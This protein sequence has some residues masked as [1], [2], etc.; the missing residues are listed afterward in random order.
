MKLV[1]VRH[2]SPSVLMNNDIGTR[3]FNGF[4]YIKQ[5]KINLKSTIIY[6]LQ[7]PGEAIHKLLRKWQTDHA[8][9]GS[10]TEGNTNTWNRLIEQSDPV[11]HRNLDKKSRH[12]KKEKSLTI[13]PEVIALC[14]E[15]ENIDPTAEIDLVE[16]GYDITELDD[17][18][19]IEFDLEFSDQE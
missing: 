9:Q 8:F 11:V 10:I 13:P 7:E 17:H 19:I 1:R 5:H 4:Y 18:N 16:E 6:I 12:R 3:T 14:K 15:P 2:L